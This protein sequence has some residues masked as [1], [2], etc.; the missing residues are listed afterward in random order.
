MLANNLPDYDQAFIVVN[1]PYYGGSGGVY[2]TSSTE[3]SSTEIAIHEIGHSFAQ[4]ADEYWAGD[5]YASEK[6]NMTQNTNPA[7]VKWRNWYGINSIGIYPYGSSGN[8]AAWF[9]PHQLCK[10]QYLN[11]PFCAV[12]RERFIDRIHQLVNMIDTYT[13]ATTSFSLTN[14]APVN[15]AV[16][17]V[18]TLPSTI[19][20]RWYL[21]GSSTPFATGVNSVSIPYANFVVG[22]NTVR[23]E[24]TDNT[25]L[26]KTYLPGIGYINNLSWTVYNAG[27]LPV[28]LSN[29]SGELINK[30]DGL[31][32]WTIETSADLAY[33]EME[34]SADGSSFKKIG[35]INQQVSS[36]VPYR[37]TDQSRMELN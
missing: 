28:K 12:C 5:S 18:E 4:L 6:P 17:H 30:K 29:F 25:T 34:K 19:T 20:V 15:F 8:P 9:R 31:L 36:A 26:S 22:N 2:A 27:A 13:P 1:S 23:A 3:A 16:A 32:K 7:T 11:Y 37:Y 14:S 24:V 33:F 21:N 35:R 10:M